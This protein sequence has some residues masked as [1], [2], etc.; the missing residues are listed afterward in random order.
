VSD[1]MSVLVGGATGQQGG[2]VATL[3]LEKGHR[4]VALTRKPESEAAARLRQAGA[5]VAVG[6]FDDRSSLEGAMRGVDAVYT[7]STSFEAGTEAETRQ[8]IAVADAAS[9]AGVAHLVY[10]S[11][12]SADRKTGIPHFES[13]YEVEQHI[14][15]LGIPYTIVG[16]A[17][18]YENVFNPFELPGLRQG[19]LATALPADRSLQQVSVRNIASF[20]V[21][22]LENR[23]GLQGKR[24]DIAS[25]EL[26]GEQ[27][28]RI[29][30][31]VSGRNIEYVQTPLEQVRAMSEEFALNLEWLIREGYSVDIPGLHRE[32]PEIGWE[33]FEEWARRQ[34]WS[35]LD[36]SDESSA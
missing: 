4:V 23:D 26:T 32:F 27:T 30:S 28:A 35:V 8:G 19:A 7:M 29:I 24:I 20:A 34:D 22:A 17:W 15:G 12:G 25:D 21:Y 14:E 10:S 18:F 31:E 13:K 1:S 16:P 11:V 3:L 33:T 6:S 36:G 5:E 2:A 9:S